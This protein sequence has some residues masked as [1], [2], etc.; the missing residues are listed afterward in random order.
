MQ[1]PPPLLHHLADVPGM[2]PGQRRLVVLLSQLGDASIWGGA[3][4]IAL[5]AKLWGVEVRMH[6]THYT[7]QSFG[8]SS[9]VWHL[10]HDNP[11]TIGPNPTTMMSYTLLAEP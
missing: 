3:L 1:T 8:S 7:T 5:A 2:E 10:G 9:Q 11:Q 6:S 4:Q